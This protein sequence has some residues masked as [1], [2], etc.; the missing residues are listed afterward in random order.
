VDALRA[1][2]DAGI[3]RP[4]EIARLYFDDAPGRQAVGARYLRDN[5]SYDLGDEERAGLTLFYRY[6]A[7]AGL[8]PRVEELRFY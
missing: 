3:A 4:D 6:A 7:D 8:V 2:R 5:I 1:A